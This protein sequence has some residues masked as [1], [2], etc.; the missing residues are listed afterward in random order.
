MNPYAKIDESQNVLSVI[1]SD[2]D[3]II[4][5][6]LQDGEAFVPISESN[7]KAFIANPRA[8]FIDGIFTIDEIPV[9]SG[10][11][12]DDARSFKIK[13]LERY[14]PGFISYHD[15]T[16]RYTKEK[17]SS[18]HG[19]YIRCERLIRL[20]ETSQAVKDACEVKIALIE[21]VYVWI[22]SVLARHYVY[23][24]AL[25][26]AETIEE[27]DA[28]TWDYSDLNTTDPDVWLEHVI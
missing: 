27:I 2:S 21:S 23:L 19:I 6:E 14:T 1:M 18:F 26:S 9:P 4:K 11:S 12:V 22:E 7:A 24:N 13:E 25:K 17:Q 3:S 16:V 28:V 5:F 15:G 8:K 20:P 10:P